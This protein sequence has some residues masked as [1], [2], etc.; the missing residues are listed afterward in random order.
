MAWVGCVVFLIIAGTFGNFT[1]AGFQGV[2]FALV[3]FG[4]FAFFVIFVVRPFSVSGG[5]YGKVASLPQ[6]SFYAD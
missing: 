2:I 3:Q 1:L 5:L 6:I 4:I